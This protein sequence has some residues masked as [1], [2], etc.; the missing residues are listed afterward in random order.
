MRHPLP[1]LLL[2]AFAG[3][4]APSP[5]CA[6]AP[7]FPPASRIGLVPPGDLTVSGK[8]M[9]FEDDAR[10]V[11]ITMLDLPEPAYQAMLKSAFAASSPH[12]TVEKREMFS[13]DGGVGYLIT[14][15]EHKDGAVLRS[16]YLLS[17]TSNREIGH[18]AALVA[19][20]VPEAARTVYSDAV[21]RAALKTVTF[22]NVPAEELIKL[23]PFKLKDLAGF[24]L[25][26]VAPEGVVILIDGPGSDLTKQPYMIVSIGRGAPEALDARPRFARDLLFS[27]P[28]ADLTITSAEGIRLGGNPSFEIR[29][30]ATGPGHVPLALVQWIRFGGGSGFLRI[31]GVTAKEHWDA[32]FP[33][34]R[35]VRD[36]IEMR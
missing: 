27:A 9:G 34:F 15:E 14:G 12:L 23:L 19:V 32:L 20:H 16:W 22:R 3:L 8:F 21:V 35:A 25:S 18:I 17:D 4:A 28:L 31:I 1:V 29:A 30:N 5:A 6:A 24:R 33:R 7:V 26:K 10:H 13:F 36:G 2:A 11:A